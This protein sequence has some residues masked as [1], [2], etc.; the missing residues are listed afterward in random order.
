MMRQMVK[1]SFLFGSRWPRTAAR[2][3]GRC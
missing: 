1:G 3:R 2:P